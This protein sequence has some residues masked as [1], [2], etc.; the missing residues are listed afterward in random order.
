MSVGEGVTGRRASNR[1]P[2]VHD[3]LDPFATTT[4]VALSAIWGLGQVAVKVVNMGLQPAFQAGLRSVLGC[5][6][7]LLWCRFRRISVFDRDGTLIPGI[8]VGLLF[9]AEFIL[10][11][12]GF[13]FTSVSRGIIFIFFAPLVVA[14]GAHYF[15]PGERLTA[16]RVVGLAAA[17]LGVVTAFSDQLSLP[18]PQAVIG[19]VLCLIAAVLWGAT[20]L[21]IKT[22]RLN[23]VAPEKVLIYQLAF[24]AP[25]MFAA[26]PFFGPLIRDLDWLVGLA[27]LY[28]VV[29]I[30]TA[31]YM[32]WFW[33][34][35]YYPAG[36]LYAFTFLSPLFTVIFGGLLLSEPLSPRLLVALA[37]VAA[38]IYLVSRQPRR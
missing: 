37:L 23:L 16:L 12:V 2:G 25:L 21:V 38:G 20:T 7:V 11:Y 9:G 10:I 18:S 30:V 28:Q 14:V 36:Q 22:T 24:S 4:L 29:V 32:V 15:I 26:V 1:R 19:D 27:F 13:D 3:V 35:A 17:F 5:L 31:S 6:L 34:I 33:L 8:I